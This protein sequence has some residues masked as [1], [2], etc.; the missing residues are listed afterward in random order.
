[1][2][3]NPAQLEHPPYLIAIVSWNGHPDYAKSCLIPQSC[4]QGKV[5]GEM[6]AQ[7]RPRSEKCPSPCAE[8]AAIYTAKLLGLNLGP[9]TAI[10]STDAPCKHCAKVIATNT[11]NLLSYERPYRPR[12]NQPKGFDPDDLQA[13]IR[14]L[15]NYQALPDNIP[16]Q[17]SVLFQHKNYNS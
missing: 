17:T 3:E 8:R 1:M 6:P 9:G 14:L 15:N 7:F 4:R 2:S 11:I 10:C 5:P 12:S 16:L 13:Q